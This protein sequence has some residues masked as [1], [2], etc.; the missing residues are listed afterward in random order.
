M[1]DTRSNYYI[2]D[3]SATTSPILQAIQKAF[4]SVLQR[5]TSENTHHRLQRYYQGETEH[6]PADTLATSGQPV[7]NP[8]LVTT[9]LQKYDISK[10][11]VEQNILNGIWEIPSKGLLQFSQFF[12]GTGNA[13]LFRNFFKER[14]QL[15]SSPDTSLA[16]NEWVKSYSQHP[17]SRIQRFEW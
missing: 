1:L 7:R 11:M 5:L 3:M 17:R 13:S 14:K 12:R 6:A 8:Q 2:A 16:G 9:K 10:W 15:Q 4:H